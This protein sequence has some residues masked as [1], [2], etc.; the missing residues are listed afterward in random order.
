M[1]AT[2]ERVRATRRGPAAR[3]L[4]ACALGSLLQ[5]CTDRSGAEPGL[6][7]SGPEVAPLIRVASVVVDAAPRVAHIWPGFRPSEPAFLVYQL[8]GAA[9]FV[10]PKAPPGFSQLPDPGLPEGLAGRAHLHP[11]PLPGLSGPFHIDYPV[12]GV[13]AMA[14]AIDSAGIPETLATFYHESFHAYQDRHLAPLLQQGGAPASPRGYVDPAL[15]ASPRFRALV[16]IERRMLISA[17]SLAPDSLP[18]ILRRYL[19][20]RRIRTRSLDPQVPL[21]E[22]AL[23]RDEGSAHLVGL[24]AALL[25]TRATPGELADLLLPYLNLPLERFPGGPSERLIRWR[26]YGTGAALGLLLERLGL[27]WRSRVQAGATFNALLAEAVAFDSTTAHTLAPAALER[28]GMAE[29]EAR[30][31]MDASNV[32]DRVD[33][34]EDFLRIS[35][36]RLTLDVAVPL[37][38]GRAALDT[39]F[40]VGEGG[41]VQ[42]EENVILF[43]MARVLS[44]ELPRV[45]LV[46][47]G[48]PVMQD[49]RGGS[50]DAPRVRFTILL[51]TLP[52]IERAS[53]LPQGDHTLH[54]LTIRSRGVHL[55]VAG[56]VTVRVGRD[57]LLVRVEAPSGQER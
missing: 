43:P 56:P 32:K 3:S 52:E 29:L 44:V 57:V 41:V 46:V 26:V 34:I 38:D 53:P 42:P 15:I 39:N 16:E 12:G 25:A 9:L 23:E 19:A 27:D 49:A 2:S 1:R 18:G 21:E 17:L 4:L 47:R 5:G 37:E 10:G 48:R 24:K 33:S 22:Q 36:I 6:G 45:S 8:D 14:V 13:R 55:T 31:M 30:A 54:G 11:G 7:A 35:P 50:R 40:L 28:F 51:P 20:V